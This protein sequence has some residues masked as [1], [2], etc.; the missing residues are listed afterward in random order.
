MLGGAGFLFLVTE[1]GELSF[2]WTPLLVGLAYLTAAA[3]G[4]RGGSYWSTAIVITGWGT[5]VVVLAETTIDIATPA[6]Y[7]LAVGVA[8]LL[9][10]ASQRRGYRT[11][12]MAVGAAIAA[13]GVAFALEPHVEL[14][15]ESWFWALAVAIVGAIRVAAPR[16][17]GQGAGSAEPVAAAGQSSRK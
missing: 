8:A 7:L 11:D 13:A 15:G 10:G 2:Y 4:G 14:F 9:A 3:I 16:T 1:V 12:T 17:A 6:G 5:A